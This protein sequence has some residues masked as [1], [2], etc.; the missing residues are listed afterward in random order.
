MA[1]SPDVRTVG[2]MI[3]LTRLRKADPLWL[4]PDHIERLEHHHETV[5]KLLNGNEYV[6]VE[7]PEEIVLQ[8]TQMRARAI[9]LAARLAVDGLDIAD[10]VSAVAATK[11]LPEVGGPAADPI[12]EATQDETRVATQEEE[13]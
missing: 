8:V 6:V 5:V 3:R 2:N 11:P 10:S 7:S 12:E 9:A 4:N 1:L 13:S